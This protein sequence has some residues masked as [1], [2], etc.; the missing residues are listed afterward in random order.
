MHSRHLASKILAFTAKQLPRDWFTRYNYKPVLFETFVQKDKFKG[1]C[2]RA[3]NWT[4]IGQ[5]K[6]RGKKDFHNRCP[7]PIP[8]LM[9]MGERYLVISATPQ[10]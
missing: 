7:L 2:Y 6:G 9:K 10:L 5:A 1:T 3:A 8:A 4:Y